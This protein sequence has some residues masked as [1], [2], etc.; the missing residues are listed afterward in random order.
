MIPLIE[1]PQLAVDPAIAV[2][3][4]RLPD[5]TSMPNIGA[6]TSVQVKLL[7]YGPG[8]DAGLGTHKGGG[9][10]PGYG[11]GYG[12]GSDQGTGDGIYTPGSG[13]VTA[14]IPIITPEAE[15]SDEARRQRYQGICLITVII[16]SHGY[17]QNPRVVQTLGMGLDEKALDAVRHY[18]F[19][20]AM[21]NGR[22]V[23]VR[24]TVEVNFRLF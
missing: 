15:F 19:K 16:D 6:H 20:P 7:S 22:P 17:P 8:L 18:R 2:E 10:G 11:V 4:I 12:P 1:H 21:K 5:N 14:P 9:D 24:I 3:N 13:G 23:P